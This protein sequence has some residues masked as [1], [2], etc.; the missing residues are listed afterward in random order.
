MAKM[1]IES[2]TLQ[3]LADA[4][5]SVTGETRTYTPTEMIE[6]VTTIMETGTYIL[7]DEAGNEIPAVFVDNTQVFTAT[8]NDIRIGTTAVTDSGVTEGTKEIPAYI[9]T[10]GIVAVPVGSSFIIPMHSD[11]CAYTKLQ[12]LL[13]KFNSSLSDSVETDRVSID[14]KVYNTQSAEAIATVTVD[15]DAQTINL[16]IVNTGDDPYVLRYFTYKEEY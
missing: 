11:K 10:E 8:A 4:L 9:T 16:G 2:S 15:I 1:I 13:C 12:A 6:A 7:V 3:G 5:R 14:G